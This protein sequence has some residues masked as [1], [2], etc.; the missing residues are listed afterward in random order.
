M[1][2][3]PSSQVLFP[4]PPMWPGKGPRDEDEGIPARPCSQEHPHFRLTR[5]LLSLHP[6]PLLPGLQVPRWI[7]A[8]L[9]CREH[10]CRPWNR[11]GLGLRPHPGRQVDPDNKRH[12]RKSIKC[13][14]HVTWFHGFISWHTCHGTLI[15]T[16]YREQDRLECRQ[17]S[18]KSGKSLSKLRLGN[19]IMLG[20]HSVPVSCST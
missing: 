19:E 8:P 10:R 15:T 12:A 17:W 5:A 3:H 11:W 4:S 16:K 9:V 18:N 6:R 2:Y 13:D 14:Y 20:T 7:Q 1:T